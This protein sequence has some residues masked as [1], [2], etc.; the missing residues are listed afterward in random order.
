MNMSK[1]ILI[2][3]VVVSFLALFSSYTNAAEIQ[4]QILKY[5]KSWIY[6]DCSNNGRQLISGQTWQVRV[7]YYLDSSEHFK[8][9]TLYLWGT[10]PFIDTPDGKYTTKREHIGYPNI[11]RQ[12]K[13]TSSG[14][15]SQLFNFI[16][17]QGLELVKRNNPILLIAGF[18]DQND[19]NWPW[20]IRDNT[21]FIDN[22]GFFDIETDVPGNLFTYNEPVKIKLKNIRN[23]GERKTASFVIYNTSG[24]IETQG[25][26]EFIAEKTD[27]EIY[28]NPEIQKCGTFLIEIDIPGWEKR[29]TTFARIPDIKAI[30]NVKPTSFGMTTSG[31]TAGEQVWAIAERLG[32]S[33]C[34]HFTKWYNIQP[35]PDIY[36]FE[37]LENELQTAHKFGIKTWLCLVDPPPFAFNN[38]AQ[39]VNYKVFDC[40]LESW[41]NF[42]STTTTKLKGK[43]YGWEWLNEIT[44]GDYKDQIQT[45]VQMCK[46]GSETA[47]SIDPNIVSLLA[48]G[49][50][51]RSFRD[52]VLSAGIGKYI[53]VL[54]VHYQNGNGVLEAR[55]DLDLAGLNNVVVW[56]NESAIGLN[57]WAVP[58]LEELE[59]TKQCDWILRQWTDELSSGCEKIIYFGGQASVAGNFGYLLDD[60][61]P[62]PVA[63]TIAVFISKLANAK[64]LGSF[65]LGKGG[66]FYLF[67]CD[68]KSVLI[69]STYEKDGEIILFNTGNKNIKITDYQG[70]EKIIPSS[71]GKTEIPLGQ[72]PFFIEN[73]DLDILKA[74]VV[75]Q[76]QVSNAGSGTSTNVSSERQIIPH[77]NILKKSKGIIS[78]NLRNIY[79]YNLSGRVIVDLP[80]NWTKLK[81]LEFN[82][83]PQEKILKEI[84][85]NITEDIP[86]KNYDIKIAL[87]FDSEK[88][89][90][91]EKHAII[92]V[93]SPEKLGNLIVNGDF[94]SP[95]SISGKPEIWNTNNT[96]KKR[97]SS[98][99]LGDGLGQFVLKFENSDDWASINQNLKLQGGQTYLYTAWV[100]NENM[101]T[102]SNMTQILKDKTQIN[103][104]DVQVIACGSNNPYWQLFTC[105]KQMPVDMESVSF[106]P[107]GK[108]P[109][110]AMWDNIRV[111]IFEGTDYAAD[112]YKTKK[113][114]KIDGIISE[115]EWVTKCPI[116]LIGQNQFSYKSDNY[117]W[118][119]DN[120]NAAGYLMWDEEN[121]YMALKV[122][123]NIHYETGSGSSVAD[124]FI[125]GDSVILGFDPT[126]RGSDSTLK[127]F[128]Y[129]ISSSSP[130]SGSGSYTLFRPEKYSGTKQA[131]HLFKDSSIYNM[132]ISQDNGICTYEL[133]IPLAELGITGNIGTKTGFSLQLNDNDGQGKEAQINW[134]NGLY[135][136]WLPDN[137][138]VIT[139]LE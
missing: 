10:G 14:R 118:K 109:G 135:P 89:P 120:L 75:P 105:R 77:I 116:P 107:L 16:V 106:T 6:I 122:R 99:G 60:Y 70:N 53:D 121:L 11:S 7:E 72:L 52:Q 26:K 66:L 61:S 13:L 8:T 79:N 4:N 133:C 112:A 28:L 45:Y 19:K 37:Q 85:V 1:S 104:Y 139:F 97:I 32:F 111:T 127:A 101:G 94:E 64:P 84:P 31:Y 58:P 128:A 95:S 92:T 123:D 100:R 56:D 102:G 2:K 18:R 136:K 78:L 126:H 9:T 15:G 134:G 62:R 131:G 30:T 93:I 132:A 54:P 129:Y 47:K 27:Q 88:L 103:L 43:L 87:D 57:A 38:I 81:P 80:D 42:I 25:Q 96:T 33:I 76:I 12:V 5:N 119:P 117:D 36:N 20:D 55:R 71:D 90:T 40:S 41:R 63:A 35:A 137:F 82:L 65:L 51:P 110:W 113:E 130:G 68:N 73:A 50:F 24:D 74:Y 34:R 29:H 115:K 48:G 108:G 125:E 17:P 67:E 69:A 49:L 22:S 91:I 44:P 98:E 124:D 46:I 83:K 59:N 138:G 21:S 39:Q 3:T 23:I 86:E 114:P